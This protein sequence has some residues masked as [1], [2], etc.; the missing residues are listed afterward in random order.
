MPFSKFGIY[1]QLSWDYEKNIINI[2]RII[3]LLTWM[4]LLKSNFYDIGIIYIS[5]YFILKNINF[6]K[7]K[8]F[9]NLII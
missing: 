9:F 4:N 7:N 3:I 6:D 8:T 5:I 2:N 1:D